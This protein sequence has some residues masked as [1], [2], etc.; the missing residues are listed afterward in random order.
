VASPRARALVVVAIVAASTPLA[1][2]IETLFR[3]SL[4]PP[5]FDEV[6]AWLEPSVTPWM[7]L[8]PF[9]AA[10]GIPLGLRLQRWLER[11][12]LASIPQHRRT[13]STAANAVLDAMLLST[14]VPQVP[15]VAATMGLLLGSAPTP[16]LVATG[17]ATAGVLVIG[18]LATRRLR[19]QTGLE[20]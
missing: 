2:A 4:F 15:A 8:T 13:P 7:W 18:L 14:S 12:N 9:A 11:R 20:K 5:E 6:R 17:V 10:L 19:E 1:V 16:V 3:R